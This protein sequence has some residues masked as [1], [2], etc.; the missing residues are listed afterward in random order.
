[1]PSTKPTIVFVPGAW[2]LPESFEAVA[3]HLTNAG[4]DYEGIHK[5][6]CTKGPDFPKTFDPDVEAVRTAIVKAADAGNEVIVVM[7]SYGGLPGSE[8]TKGLSK[9]DRAKD[10]KKG[11]VTRL[12]YITAFALP[13]GVSLMSAGGGKVAPWCIEEVFA[14]LSAS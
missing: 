4:Y 2:H 8:A 11:G 7:H 10:G 3:S 12:I 9:E 6:S 5:P 1:M 13:E 14:H